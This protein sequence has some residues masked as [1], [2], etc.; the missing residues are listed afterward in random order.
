M[1]VRL[2]AGLLMIA[3]ILPGCL[4]DPAEPAAATDTAS[5]SASQSGNETTDTGSAAANVTNTPP[6]ANV[7]AEPTN[8]SMPLLVNFTITISD[9][10]GDA[11]NWTLDADADGATDASGDATNTSANFTYV[12]EGLYNATL[13]VTDGTDTVSANVTINVTAGAGGVPMVLAEYTDSGT[14]SAYALTNSPEIAAQCPGFLTGQDGVGCVFLEF[15]NGPHDG[16]PAII[17]TNAAAVRMAFW[18]TCSPTGEGAGFYGGASGDQVTIPVGAGCAILWSNN[19]ADTGQT[20]S[21]TL[22]IFDWLPEEE[23]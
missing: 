20:R 9:D 11:L 8:G 21:F 19:S 22:Q 16:A 17:T 6:V 23:E 4:A 13:N 12:V 10:D 14:I 18:S 15:E 7:S 5:P 2:A 3:I 1:N